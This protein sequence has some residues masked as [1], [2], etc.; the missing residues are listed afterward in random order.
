MR[1]RYPA[2]PMSTTGQVAGQVSEAA[3]EPDAASP[4]DT[5]PKWA[6]P[7][8]PLLWTGGKPCACLSGN[9]NIELNQGFARLTG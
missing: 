9:V 8:R 2:A 1:G 5:P 4:I 3:L 6:H 7:Q